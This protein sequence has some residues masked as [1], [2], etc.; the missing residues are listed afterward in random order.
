MKISPSLLSANFLKLQDEIEAIQ[1]AG[2]DFLHL[3]VMDGHFVP[4]LTFGPVVIE[5][6]AKIAKIPLDVHLMVKNISFFVELFLPFA[7]KFISFHLEEETHPHR[8]ANY[9]RSKGVS[10]CVVLNPHTPLEGLEYLLPE[11]DMVLL[12]SVNPGFGGQSFIPQTLSKISKLKE[13][14]N[15]VNPQC[16]IQVDGGVNE[17]NAPLIKE[18]GGDILVA[19]NYIFKSSDYAKSINALRA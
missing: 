7:P 14:I 8:L 5:Q 11:L 1:E 2:A 16:L 9:L 6:I 10:P 18:A 3:D 4:N 19:G 12:M 13:K 15:Q 17:K